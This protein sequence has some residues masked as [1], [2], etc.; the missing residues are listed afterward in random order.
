MARHKQCQGLGGSRYA[1][2]TE[3]QGVT[4]LYWQITNKK[5]FSQIERVGNFQANCYKLFNLVQ[6]ARIMPCDSVVRFIW[7]DSNSKKNGFLSLSLVNFSEIK[8]LK[9]IIFAKSLKLNAR[10]N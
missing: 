7:Q 3:P 1:D 4:P 10:E 5:P 8:C 2:L 9:L 6:A